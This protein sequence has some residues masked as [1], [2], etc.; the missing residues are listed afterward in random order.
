MRLRTEPDCEVSVLVAVGEDE[1]RIGHTIRK[2]AS[3]L[4]S[5]G[6]RFELVAADEQSS[7]NSLSM[8]ALAARETPELE[9]LAGAREGEGFGHA[10]S[11]AR[12]RLVLTLDPKREVALG[13]LAWGLG[14]IEAGRDAVV[15]HGRYVL[16]RRLLAWPALERARGR[17]DD[18][19][20]SFARRARACGLDIE[21]VRK[22]TPSRLQSLAA[23]L[24]R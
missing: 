19:D 16:A 9:V 8:L 10:A 18:F 6:V 5:L 17:A 24:R 21:V 22:E 11:R 15:L 14:R 23:R 4:R 3:H 7:D 12:G 20:H 2:A 1:E 13:T